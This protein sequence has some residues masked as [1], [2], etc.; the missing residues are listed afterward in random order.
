MERITDDH[1]VLLE[2]TLA[3]KC[4]VSSEN[5]KLREEQTKR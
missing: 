3:K 4:E 2:Q 1:V 5:Q